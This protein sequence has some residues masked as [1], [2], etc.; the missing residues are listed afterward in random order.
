MLLLL[1]TA[2]AAPARPPFKLV[3][4][5]WSM[6]FTDICASSG[7]RVV[8]YRDDRAPVASVVSVV[9]GGSAEDPPGK[10]GLAHLVEHLWFR[11]PL[12]GGATVGPTLDSFAISNAFTYP[13]ET[14]YVSEA[15][16]AELPRLLTIEGHRFLD[17]LAKIDPAV[18]NAEVQIV[19]Q[20][21]RRNDLDDAG[22]SISFLFK[23]LFRRTHPYARLGLDTPGSMQNITLADVAAYA[24]T[25]FR[26]ERMTLTVVGAMDGESARRAVWTAFPDPAIGVLTGTLPRP[27][28]RFSAPTA[29]PPSPLSTD[30]LIVEVHRPVAHRELVF[31]WTIPGGW[32]EPALSMAPVEY[33]VADMIATNASAFDLAWPSCGTIRMR[34]TS[35]LS[36]SVTV[37]DQ[38]NIKTLADNMLIAMEYNASATNDRYFGP[39]WTY[40]LLWHFGDV[41]GGAEAMISPL[42]SGSVDAFRYSHAQG[43]PAFHSALWRALGGATYDNAMAFIRTW[44]TPDRAVR[45]IIEPAS[46]G[47]PSMTNQY[48]LHPSEGTVLPIVSPETVL[49][50]AAPIDAARII[51]R[52]LEN[53]LTVVVV[54]YGDV[55]MV[56]M[57]LVFRGGFLSGDRPGLADVVNQSVAWYP[58]L[59]SDDLYEEILR[60]GVRTE[61][62][63][64][65]TY[66]GYRF[67]GPSGNLPE[68][69]WLAY[70]RV[71]GERIERGATRDAAEVLGRAL[72]SWMDGPEGQVESIAFTRLFNDSPWVGRP[73]HSRWL[74]AQA[75]PESR[76]QA[77]FRGTRQPGNAFLVVA[78]A[79][80]PA[81]AVA[82]AESWFGQW[83][84]PKAVVPARA[85][86][87]IGP[88]PAVEEITLVDMPALTTA[89]VAAAC[90]LDGEVGDPRLGVV[91]ARAAGMATDALR[92]R[93]GLAYDPWAAAGADPVGGNVLEIGATLAPAAV[94]DGRRLMRTILDS[95]SATTEDN[96][97]RNAALA[98]ANG[99]L[100]RRATIPGMLSV[101]TEATLRPTGL[102]SLQTRAADLAAVTAA[103]IRRL[104]LPC[105]SRIEYVALGQASL[106][107]GP[108]AASGLPVY[109][110]DWARF[111]REQTGRDSR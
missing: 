1:A 18:F 107:A 81:S 102:A 80:D 49:T 106:M 63:W 20:E 82:L 73:T 94:E 71:K 2:F 60:V 67:T 96:A 90:R 98:V 108:L 31:A 101:L 5:D 29:A 104:M 22:S 100:V 52:T 55:P 77:L 36:C 72:E 59:A 47:V 76:W 8:S 68:M 57:D 48:S 92:E 30:R 10:E 39:L 37:P 16:V 25:H 23:D 88:L 84:A 50:R 105:T 11:A 35:I 53:G 110:V 44:I 99:G 93:T 14:V 70:S 4:P 78:G 7:L 15:P 51:T 9:E 32:G 28:G 79:V 109:P 17:P 61:E 27:C 24:S 83:P 64:D 95:L 54:P 33:V 111:K 91:Q 46:N 19:Q 45:G 34:E 38:R 6:N 87:P 43:E 75:L 74:A 103:D 85:W 66:S 3:V 42:S 56:A 13:D 58:H 26:P 41:L 65:E 86:D 97:A 62:R 89:R 12:T 40:A 69:M 21:L